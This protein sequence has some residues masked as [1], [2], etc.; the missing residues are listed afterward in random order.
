[1]ANLKEAQDKL[2]GL[3]DYLDGLPEEP[4]EDLV[5]N[6]VPAEETEDEVEGVGGTYLTVELASNVLHITD[7]IVN[8]TINSWDF[9]DEAES[10]ELLRRIRTIHGRILT[11]LEK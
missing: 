10:T 7:S 3:K 5:E 4:S 11:H 2:R 6:S 9:A 8:Q 1:M